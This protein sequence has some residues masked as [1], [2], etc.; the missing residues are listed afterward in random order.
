MN[1]KL[2]LKKTV[3]SR[4]EASAHLQ[5]PGDAVLVERG[6]LRWLLLLC[7]CGCG[8][9]LPINLDPRAGPAWRFYR[10]P[11]R[12][13]SVYPSVWRESD[14]GSHFIVW[15]NRILLFDREDD[16][17]RSP[18]RLEEL[19]ALA[20]R[21]REQVPATGVISYVDIADSLGE[22]PWDALSACRYLVRAG[23]LREEP[24]KRRGNFGRVAEQDGWR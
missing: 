15:R 14:C 1:P 21:V 8:A 3:P 22:V 23:I 6:T 17:F 4:R 10:D 19:A 5:S 9:E 24:G 20:A 13:I 18:E 11:S 12:G 7:P 2:K 16:Y